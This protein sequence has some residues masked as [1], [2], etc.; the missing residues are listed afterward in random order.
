MATVPAI[1]RSLF[2]PGTAQPPHGHVENSTRAER[3]QR[4]QQA[5]GLWRVLGP[6][7]P[8]I[9]VGIPQ[10]TSQHLCRRHQFL[11]MTTL[12]TGM[13]PVA[14][15]RRKEEESRQR[16]TPLGAGKCYRHLQDCCEAI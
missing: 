7:A 14:R 16:K 15:R 4:R 10:A 2:V 13:N 3:S 12:R 8:V 6:T 1:P 11:R 5:R 9:W